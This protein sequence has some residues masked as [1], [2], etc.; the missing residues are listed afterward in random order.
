MTT[1]ADCNGPCETYQGDGT[2]C[3]GPLLCPAAIPGA[4]CLPNGTCI[5]TTACQCTAQ[6]GTPQSFGSSCSDPGI[7]PV[8]VFCTDAS[9]KGCWGDVLSF[10]V[11]SVN[12]VALK[13]GKVLISHQSFSA[14]VCP[15]PPG[16]P[17]GR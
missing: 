8:V 1:S 11:N 4:C 14:G 2:N 16:S 9:T 17:T 13:T 5:D 12:M 7:C 15:A 6:G 3:A 10:D